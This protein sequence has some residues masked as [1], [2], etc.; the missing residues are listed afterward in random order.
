MRHRSRQLPGRRAGPSARQRHTEPASVIRRLSLEALEER[1][2]LFADFGDAPEPYPTLQEFNGAQHLANG[3]RLGALRDTEDDGQPTI[4]ADGDDNAGENDEDG[5]TLTVLT[6][7]QL[8]ASIAV[9]VQNASGGARLDAW[10]DFDSDGS[11]GGPSEHVADGVAVDAGPNAV[12]FAVPSW[13][14]DGSHAARFRIATTD[15]LGAFG[16]AGDGEVEDHLVTITE[17]VPAADVFGS[18]KTISDSADGA[19]SVAT[20]DV[21]GDGDLDVL[22][23]SFED[24]TIAW[25]END[26]SQG[27]T[28]H[29]ISDT[30]DGASCVATADVDGDGDLDVL[31]ASFEDDT[32]AWY[33]NDG[34][35]GFTLRV[36]SDTADGASSVR[37]GRP[38]DGGR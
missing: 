16:L 21:D 22:S 8:G 12:A 3:P 37:G 32:I 20:A 33:E 6:T 1:R 25:Y 17:A 27:F 5:V 18:R 14:T 2:L 29:V 26:G 11:W 23:A 15:D 34:S 35:Q 28:L 36:I 9:D 10:I 4:A 38:V 13:A 24:D 30:A 7:G 31:S 19:S